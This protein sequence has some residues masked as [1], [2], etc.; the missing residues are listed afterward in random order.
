M[1][2]YLLLDLC[3]TF[4]GDEWPVK[5]DFTPPFVRQDISSLWRFSIGNVKLQL[6]AIK[7]RTSAQRKFV[8]EV[9]YHWLYHASENCEDVLNARFHKASTDKGLDLSSLKLRLLPQQVVQIPAAL[10]STLTK[11][12]LASNYIT[13]VPRQIFERVVNLNVLKLSD[14]RMRSLPSTISCLQSLQFCLL[15]RNDFVVLT[16]AVGDLKLLHTLHIHDN[17]N[18]ISFPLELG[19]KH[20]VSLGG[21]VR[22]LLYDYDV[23]EYPPAEVSES[24]IAMQFDFLSRM[25]K[26]TES[27]YLSLGGMNLRTVPHFLYEHPLRTTITELNI[28]QN[29]IER[30][31]P[32]FGMMTN[33]TTLRIDENLFVFPSQSMM[34]QSLSSRDPESRTL[35]NA[36]TLPFMHFLRRIATCKHTREII[37]SGGE[38]EFDGTRVEVS[39]RL[40]APELFLYT[41][42]TTLDVRSNYIKTI[43]DVLSQ[44]VTLTKFLADKNR[45][46]TVPE[47]LSRVTCLQVLSLAVNEIR[48]LPDIF[49]FLV[50]LSLLNVSNNQLKLLPNS[51]AACEMLSHLYVDHNE[52]HSFPKDFHRL[53][54]LK[55]FHFGHNPISQL[56]PQ[57]GASW[58]LE[59]VNAEGCFAVSFHCPP[60]R[61][62]S[63]QIQES[64]QEVLNGSSSFFH[65]VEA[66]QSPHA[67]FDASL[68]VR[69]LASPAGRR[70][71][72]LPA[73]MKTLA[74]LNELLE[75]LERESDTRV[76]DVM[77]PV[78]LEEEEDESRMIEYLPPETIYSRNWRLNK[79]AQVTNRRQGS[80]SR[81]SEDPSKAPTVPPTSSSRP[82]SLGVMVEL[83]SRTGGLL[84]YGNHS[85]QA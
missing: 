63:S 31:P 43:P 14:N 8:K 40:M 30:L 85:A 61:L 4:D 62:S 33:L 54:R 28:S 5:R 72:Q 53:V 26:A 23:V 9:F 17:P 25:W 68:L 74:K 47:I 34:R 66:F 35:T 22:E 51:I 13:F 59:E 81:Q 83:F 6:L 69:L 15:D 48:R 32:A 20:H 3:N 52:L 27:G 73:E 12:D 11:L 38:W 29:K 39:M 64:P 16:P 79:Q 65:K 37:L 71:T 46:R 41:N 36:A 45:I 56:S 84:W 60:L 75:R 80:K 44:L 50:H 70:I 57:L 1:E 76:Q 77:F 18:F 10:A 82:L 42:C 24:G 2:S 55:V 21:T 19:K 58:N 78:G 7:L 49:S 67:S